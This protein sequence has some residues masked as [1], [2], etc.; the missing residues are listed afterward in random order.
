MLVGIDGGDDFRIV[1][2]LYSQ[3]GTSVEGLVEADEARPS[4]VEG[5]QFQRVLVG[6]GAA[7]DEEQLIVVVAADLAQAFGQLL[8]QLVD[9]RV[10]V[11]AQ[12]GHLLA[13]HLHVVRVGM[14]DGD[15]GV[16]AI[17]V[18]VFSAL[19]V[20]YVAAFAPHDVDVEQGIYVKEFHC[21]SS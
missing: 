7:V 15:D 12:R 18:K 11:E 21:L 20:P 14:A 16:A 19:F 1:R 2:H 17:E 5:G 13:D 6:F 4:V 3:G 8:L 10:G 9:D